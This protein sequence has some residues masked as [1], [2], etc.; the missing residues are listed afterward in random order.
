MQKQKPELLGPGK[1]VRGRRTLGGDPGITSPGQYLRGP[2]S[3]LVF[4]LSE[5]LV[6]Y[7][8]QGWFLFVCFVLYQIY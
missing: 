6:E 2:F 8:R 5:I 4:D 3:L 1:D 7:K